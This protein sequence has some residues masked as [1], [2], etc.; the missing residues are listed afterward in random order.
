MGRERNGP[1]NLCIA[2]GMGPWSWQ[3]QLTGLPAALCTC[4]VQQPLE[5]VSLAHHLLKKPL[6]KH[7]CSSLLGTDVIFASEQVQYAWAE[8]IYGNN[9]IL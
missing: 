3:A 1:P 6:Q 2:V 4:L 8:N 7:A 5:Q 9:I